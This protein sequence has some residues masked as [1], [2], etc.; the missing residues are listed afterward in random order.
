MQV[1]IDL[2]RLP[3]GSYGN[4]LGGTGHTGSAVVFVCMLPDCGS[5]AATKLL[6]VLS[7]IGQSTPPPP[8]LHRKIEENIKLLV[9]KQYYLFDIM[10]LLAWCSLVTT[11]GNYMENRLHRKMTSNLVFSL[12]QTIIQNLN[13]TRRI[14]KIERGVE[15]VKKKYIYL[16]AE[17]KCKWKGILNVQKPLF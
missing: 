5:R 14:K 12:C 8:N 15:G 17:R 4:V 6:Q 16:H 9:Y 11:A 2:K 10:E 3:E 13:F 7:I 1:Y